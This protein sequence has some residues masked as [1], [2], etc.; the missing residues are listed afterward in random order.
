LEDNLKVTV[1]SVRGK[2]LEY[3]MV[4]YSDY[5]TE[6]QGYCFMVDKMIIFLDEED[7]SIA[8]M[9]QADT[10]PEDSATAIMILAEI[11]NVTDISIMESFI[12]DEKRKMITGNKA[13]ELVKYGIVKSAFT[14]VARETAYKEILNN[15]K[16]YEC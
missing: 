12:Y 6:D 9:F 4:I 3:G 11:E 15:V 5:P 16:G 2:L 10:Y 1:E 7:D 14:H 8:V 13:H